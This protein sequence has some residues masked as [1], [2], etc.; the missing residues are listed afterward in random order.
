[1][2]TVLSYSVALVLFVLSLPILMTGFIFEVFV[3]AFGAGRETAKN[4]MD[5]AP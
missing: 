3:V 5:F 4:F 1:M 2:K